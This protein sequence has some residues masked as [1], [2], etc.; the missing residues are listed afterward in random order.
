VKRKKINLFFKKI[1]KDT[2]LVSLCVILLIIF[3]FIYIFLSIPFEKFDQKFQDEAQGLEIN[4]IPF[5]EGGSVNISSWKNFHTFSKDER[6]FYEFKESLIQSGVVTQED[7]RA[8]FHASMEMFDLYQNECKEIYCFQ[9]RIPFDHIDAI[10]WKGLIG[11][12][13][14]RF[15]DHHGVDF[16]SLARAFLVD[17]RK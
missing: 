13:D 1:F 17:L 11:I 12:E 14:T 4:K 15:L 16:R 6:P 7:G 5:E 10:F 8:I 9:I 2:L 3:Y